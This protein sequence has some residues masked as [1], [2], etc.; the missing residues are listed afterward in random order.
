MEQNGGWL[1]AISGWSLDGVDTL[2]KSVED[3]NSITV[4][5]IKAFATQLRAQGNYR[6][7]VL[8]PAQ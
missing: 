8:D 6:V 7:V 2:T 4:D 1:A 3:V 5:D